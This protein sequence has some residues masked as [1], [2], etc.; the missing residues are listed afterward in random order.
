MRIGI[1]PVPNWGYVGQPLTTPDL[2][3]FAAVLLMEP[4]DKESRQVGKN[5]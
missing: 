5:T 1:L 4:E 2:S 3:C